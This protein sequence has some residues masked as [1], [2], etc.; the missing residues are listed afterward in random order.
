MG[1]LEGRLTRLDRLIVGGD[2]CRFCGARHVWTYA[3]LVRTQ[4]A[5]VNVCD[6]SMCPCSR[7]WKALAVEFTERKAI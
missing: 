3:D 2:L 7:P 1:S 4:S 5:G 6:C